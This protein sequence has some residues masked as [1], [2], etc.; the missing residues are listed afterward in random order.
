MKHAVRFSIFFILAI[1]VWWTITSNYSETS[2]LAFDRSKQFAEVFMHD[3][4]MT[5]MNDDGRPNYLLNGSYLQ[6]NTGSHNTMIEQPV[7]QMLKKDNRW[8]IVADQAIFNDRKETI[9]LK[10]NVVMQQQN[11]DSAVTIR[12][13]YLMINTKTQIAKTDSQIDLTRGKSRLKSVGMTYDNNTSEL[14]LSSNVNGYYF[15]HD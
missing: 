7:F 10:N 15:P 4:S 3:F 12:T 11:T 2:K 6:R 8:K 5:A 14:E 13:D 9:Q 1:V